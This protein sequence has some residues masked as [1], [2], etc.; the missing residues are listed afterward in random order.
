MAFG[1]PARKHKIIGEARDVRVI[2]TLMAAA[3][4]RQDKETGTE[5]NIV[6]N[7]RPKAA[8]LAKKGNMNPPR[9]PPATVQEIA[10]NFPNATR[11]HVKPL[12][13]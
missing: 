13:I 11:R 12:F 2:P 10:I 4:E 1:S 5:G 6:Q 9:Y 8:P 3:K 7:A